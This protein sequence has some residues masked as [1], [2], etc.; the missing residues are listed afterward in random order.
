MNLLFI[1]CYK[2]QFHLNKIQYFIKAIHHE[3][4]TKYQIDSQFLPWFLFQNLFGKEIMAQHN[5][6][7]IFLPKSNKL[8]YNLI[9]N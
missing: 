6:L 7:N 2:Y 9:K 8:K 5:Y 4:N 3:K 1:H